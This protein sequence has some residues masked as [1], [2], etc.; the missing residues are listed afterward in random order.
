V[1]HR[2]Y[3][4][5][6]TFKELSFRPGLNILLADKSLG[7]T[8]R[9]TRN[10]AGKSSVIEVIHF[11]LGARRDEESVLSAAALAEARFGME[12]NLGAS[13]IDVVRSRK[14]MKDVLIKSGD[15]TGWPIE[16]GVDRGTGFRVISNTEWQQVLGS[17]MFG[18]PSS[19]AMGKHGPTFRSLI[20]YFSR[21]WHAGGFERPEKHSSKQSVYDQQVALTYLLG[22]D[23]SIPQEWES[24][25][26]TERSLEE[27]RKAA[28]A[29]LLDALVG[30]SAAELRT[31]L[32]LAENRAASLRGRMGTF[33]V[34]PEYHSLET[35]ASGLT[36]RISELLDQDTIDR[37][38]VKEIEKALADERPPSLE[39]VE[40]VY[41]EVGVVL[42]ERVV[43]KFD[44]A[45]RFREAIIKNRASYLAGELGAANRRIGDRSP[46]VERLSARRAQVMRIL[47]SQ[48]ALDHFAELQ[49]ELAR[50]EAGVESL[51]HR[52]TAAERLERQETELR[53]ERSLLRQRLMQ[54]YYEQ[55]ETLGRAIIAFQEFST[56]LYEQAG[57][58]HAEP[59]DNGPQF[60]V[61]IQGDR[62]KG[63]RNMQTF[64]L[65]MTL[66]ALSSQRSTGPGFLVHDSHLFDGVDSRQIAAALSVGA[67]T[68]RRR[69]FQ[70]IVTL[71]SDDLPA[72]HSGSFRAADYVLPVK[73]TD[74][75]EDGGL[76]G[77]RFD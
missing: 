54:D 40:H 35:E 6:P 70:Y 16:P 45:R 32:A 19:H 12:F 73:L 31:H 71:N 2:V 48:G 72:D 30:G 53:I 63:I 24:I 23:W 38:L 51:R 11:L 57:N 42:P 61:R 75:S 22:L 39:S 52:F 46:L 3:S 65:D 55:K 64:C 60:E 58:L 77:F 44:E 25:R 20:S 8:E 1:I 41:A 59:T 18:L 47:S 27:L 29:G 9:Q 43:R 13:R 49:S 5:L 68:S 37:V 4:D 28:R 62:S 56:Q 26:Q 69:G 74:A 17:I 14:Q 66:M 7:A 76:F 50:V 10:A 15:T 67:D 34:H 21:R 36:E 33:V